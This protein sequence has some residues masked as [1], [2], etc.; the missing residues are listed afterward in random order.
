MSQSVAEKELVAAAIAGDSAALEQLLFENFSTLERYVEPK[1]PA[2]V[3]QHVGAEDLLQDVMT[4]AFRDIRHFQYRAD[5]GFVAWLK[6]I[7]D[8][9]T[10]DTLKRIRRKKRG[11]D[12]H[13]V[14]AA[15]VAQSSTMATLFDLICQDS[16]LPDKSAARREAEQAL[17]V[18]L[19]GLPEDQRDAI[20]A[21]FLHGKDVAQI[22]LEMGRT[23]DAVRGLIH[24][25][26]KSLAEAMGRSSRWLSSQ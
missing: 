4:Q 23:P 20:R 25:G 5:G 3:R 21:N 13:Q 1:I 10:T 16:N 2:D 19:A 9:R 11:G 24:R 12:R 22:A 18:A 6:T 17:Q 26:K 15:D 14:T 8:H 7:A